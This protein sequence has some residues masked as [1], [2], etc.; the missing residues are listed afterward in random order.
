MC[1]FFHVPEKVVSQGGRFPFL[2]WET[3]QNTTIDLGKVLAENYHISVG[4]IIF[5]LN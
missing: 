2:Y 4:D 1:N 5:L 3:A